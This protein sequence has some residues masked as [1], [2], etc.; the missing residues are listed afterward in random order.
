MIDVLKCVYSETF[1]GTVPVLYREA[2]TA[3]GYKV[4]EEKK[5][6]LIIKGGRTSE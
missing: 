6:F 5:N 1:S 2:Y 3:A 4:V